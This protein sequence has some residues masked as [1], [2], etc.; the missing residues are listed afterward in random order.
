MYEIMMV[1]SLECSSD[2][3]V[4]PVP[5]CRYEKLFAG[6]A[7]ANLCVSEAMRNDLRRT[8]GVR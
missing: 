8:L 7:Y 5:C 6:F 3:E 4:V 1:V 2:S